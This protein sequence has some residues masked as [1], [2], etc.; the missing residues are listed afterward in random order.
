MKRVVEGLIKQVASKVIHDTQ[1]R[2][3]QVD[4]LKRVYTLKG[5]QNI[6][7]DVPGI[8]FLKTSKHPERN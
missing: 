8:E 5:T 6:Q 1:I 3:H 4:S 7:S 2:G